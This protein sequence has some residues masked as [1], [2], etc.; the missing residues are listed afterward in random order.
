MRCLSIT[1]IVSSVLV[2]ILCVACLVINSGL[3]SAA[4]LTTCNAQNIASEVY[5]GNNNTTIPWS[6]INN[7]SAFIDNT[8]INSENSLPFLQ[9]YFT[10][11]NNAD[12]AAVVSTSGSSLY[13]NVITGFSGC[14]PS[15]QT[16]ACPFADSAQCTSTSI[17]ALFNEN[18]CDGNVSTSAAA[19]INSE[20]A[21]NSTT[22]KDSLVNLSATLASINVSNQ[23][24][25]TLK[26]NVTVFSNSVLEYETQIN[27]GLSQVILII[28][29]QQE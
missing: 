26:S 15:S 2:I 11:A 28:L 22:W 8:T 18:F 19:Q 17:E 6:G 9:E 14:V 1:F 7:F 16:I 23:F 20:I 27:D 3:I 29:R 13:D 12:L 5:N 21:T 10:T 24:F 4:R 25:T